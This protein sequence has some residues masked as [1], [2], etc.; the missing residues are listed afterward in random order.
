MLGAT[1]LIC[2]PVALDYSEDIR[3]GHIDDGISTVI[4]NAA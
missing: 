1:Y 4:A 3:W 2:P